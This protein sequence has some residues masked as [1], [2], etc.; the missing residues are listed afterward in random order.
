MYAHIEKFMYRST[1]TVLLG[2]FIQQVHAQ[3]L[4][5]E[6]DAPL[7]VGALASIH[8]SA[9]HVDDK[10]TA[11]PLLLYDNNRFYLE[12]TDVAFDPYKD[13]KHWVRVGIS[14]DRQHYNSKDA[15]TAALQ[16]LNKRQSS[17]NAQVSY[18]YISAIGGIETKL[19]TD[20]LG[21]SNGQTVSLAHR[22]KFEL[23]DNKLTVYPKAGITWHSKKYNDYYY[24]ISDK[25]SLQS[26]IHFY[27][28]KLVFHLLL[29][30]VVNTCLQIK[31]VV[32]PM[33]VMTGYPLVKKIVQ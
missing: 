7:T 11:V 25:E 33:C 6:K 30:L 10:I 15:K 32:L 8:Q 3:T 17:V 4:A 26:G 20:I 27:D 13:N 24:G 19:A 9:Y 1:L 18:M 22:S 29:L 21:R 14:Y 16:S 5:M 31:L 2:L 28:A 12:G 23:L